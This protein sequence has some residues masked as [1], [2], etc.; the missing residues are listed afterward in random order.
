MSYA[1]LA[2]RVLNEP[3]FLESEFGLPFYRTGMVEGTLRG[4]IKG[5]SVFY[6]MRKIA[7]FRLAPFVFS[8]LSIIQ[9]AG[10]PIKKSIGYPSFGGG[11]R[12]RNENLVFGTIEVRGYFL[13]RATDGFKNW[14][15]ELSTN[16]KF[17]Y[18]SN[19]IHKPAF[20]TAN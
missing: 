15:V 10:S 20:I 13:P 8:G 12:T 18:N 14:K 9:P 19:F 16:L 3:L 7:G 1:R 6:H 11:V 17:K 2:K 5:E 4:T